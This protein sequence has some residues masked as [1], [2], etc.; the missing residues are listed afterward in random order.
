MIIK[1]LFVLQALLAIGLSSVFLIPQKTTLGPAGIGMTLPD[2]VGRWTSKAAPVAPEE[3]KGLAE[4]TK[5]VRRWY[6]N[7]AG[8]QIYVSIVLSGAD[9]GNSI[10][11]PE[12]CLV[13]QDWSVSSS[14]RVKIPLP[15]GKPPLEVTALNVVNNHE[16]RAD[17]NAAPVTLRRLN[18]YWFIGSQDITASHWTR[19]F[20]D[21]RDRLLH[22]DNQRWAYVT[23][24]ATVTDNLQPAGRTQEETTKIIEDFLAEIVPMFQPGGIDDDDSAGNKTPKAEVGATPV[25]TPNGI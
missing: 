9:M 8:D 11:R 16:Y 6:S 10:H 21:I 18:Y 24:A 25:P 7:P 23:V 1:R 14:R 12:R 22:G 17:R 20:I 15:A 3:L 4:D 19:T 5:F 2:Q 13:A